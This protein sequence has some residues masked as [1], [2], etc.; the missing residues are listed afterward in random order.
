[1]LGKDLKNNIFTMVTFA[2]CA[3]PPV[4]G[5]IREAVIP[6]TEHFQFNNSALYTGNTN[7]FAKMFW[8]MG[9]HKSVLL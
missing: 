8:E 1:M 5:A 3:D 6:C 9:M 7:T 2:D 4:I